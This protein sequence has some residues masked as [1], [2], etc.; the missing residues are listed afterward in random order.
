MT[1][2][3]KCIWN[4]L[5][6]K[7]FNSYAIAGVMANI[8]VESNL[9]PNNLEDIYSRKF[10]LSNEEYTKRVNN[11]LYQNFVHDSAG[12]GLC[13]WTY[14]SRKQNL[15]NLAK[16]RN[17]SIDNIDM[18]LDF[19]IQ[20]L[21]QMPNL[22]NILKNASSVKQA[23]DAFMIQFENPY[24]KS[25]TAKNI[26]ANF[27]LNLY[28]Q[29]AKG[30]TTPTMG[31]NI[32]MKG[33][34]VKLS[35]HFTSNEFDCHGA[36]CCNQTRINSKLVEYVQKIRDHFNKPIT[37]TSGYRCPNHNAA[38]GGATGSR[39]SVGDAADIVVQGIAPATVAAYAES[40]GIK[41]IGL[42]ETSKDGHFIHIDT[43][44][45]KSFWY[46]QAQAPRTTF[47]SETNFLNPNNSNSSNQTNLIISFGSRGDNVKQLQNM[48][49]ALDYNCGTADGIF[50]NVTLL[51][52]KKFQKEHNLSD[53]G[54]VGPATQA[55]LQS[56]SKLITKSRKVKVIAS[57]LNVREQPNTNSKIL[58]RL[59]NGTIKTIVSEE[60]GWSKLE[61]NGWVC[62][63]YVLEV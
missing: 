49:N 43:R 29:Y 17:V 54:I 6:N 23:S 11:G 16:Q 45:Y 63:Q 47:M 61:D 13:Q 52:V 25:E 42:Y 59:P 30:G 36:G 15:L 5:S 10:G 32:Y 46:G 53:D 8:K 28:N 34:G 9:Q 21:N 44:D 20:E 26:R 3:H 19:L 40:I 1:D 33:S 62:S 60:N 51:M 55:A 38:V 31:T 58:C 2:Y 37:I 18:Q 50:G 4:Y 48:L 27:G 39:H 22:M 35:T 12:Y 7:G 56:A 14:Y 57:L 24:D 41:G